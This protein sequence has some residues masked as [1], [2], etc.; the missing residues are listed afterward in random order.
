MPEGPAPIAI[1]RVESSLGSMMVSA[2]VTG[3]PALLV[4][5]S[6][7]DD[8]ATVSRAEGRLPPRLVTNTV[9]ARDTATENGAT[10]AS[11]VRRTVRASAST[12]ATALSRLR[13]T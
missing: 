10:P 11:T 9:P 3:A 7:P 1:S 13:A 2:P 8:G 6:V 12:T 5:T 4:A